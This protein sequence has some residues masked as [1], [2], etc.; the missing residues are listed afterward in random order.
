[1][2]HHNGSQSSKP[3]VAGNKQSKPRARAEHSCC[4][5]TANEVAIFGGWAD[6]PLNDLWSF[7]FVDME[8][9]VLVSSGIQPRPRY[10]HSAEFIGNNLYILGG[11][12]NNEDIPEQS[13]NLGI[14]VLSL[15]TMQWSHPPLSG[16]FNPFPRSGHGSTVIG[17]TTIA[18]FGGKYNNQ[19]FS[20]SIAISFL[21]SLKFGDVV[22][23]RFSSTIWSYWMSKLW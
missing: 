4:K 20:N 22:I 14:H 13:R 3:V 10:R 15:S 1:M 23:S 9:R 21:D 11:S 7:N 19:V 18:I 5:I 8:W 12:D 2:K 17:V 16:G 6:R